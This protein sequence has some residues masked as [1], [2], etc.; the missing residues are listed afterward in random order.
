MTHPPSADQISSPPSLSTVF[1]RR[2]WLQLAIHP[3]G[4]GP[5]LGDVAV[6]R[7]ADQPDTLEGEWTTVDGFALLASEC[8]QTREYAMKTSAR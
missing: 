1:R 5:L 7:L 3:V 6:N 4:G 2:A 8:R